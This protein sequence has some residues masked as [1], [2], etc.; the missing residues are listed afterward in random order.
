MKIY[1]A[2]ASRSSFFLV[3][4]D[5]IPTDSTL[6][7]VGMDVFFVNTSGGH[8]VLFVSSNQVGSGFA[9]SVITAT[10]PRDCVCSIRA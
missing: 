5:T 6:A 9:L 10:N 7:E 1:G 8:A 4:G 3:D 2:A